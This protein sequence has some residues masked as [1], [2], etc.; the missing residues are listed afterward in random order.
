MVQIDC[1]IISKKQ[2][3][4]KY[5]LLTF[6][7]E[8]IAV[9][10]LP[11]QFVMVQ[12]SNEKIFLRRPFSICSAYSKT[13]DIF[14]KV[15]GVGSELLSKKNVGDVL[16]IIGPL[17]NGYH[18]Q[19]PSSNSPLLVAGGTG[20]ASILFLAQRF[21]LHSSRPTVFLGAKTKKDV[22][23]EKEFKKLGYKVIV[24][25]ED[26][27]EGSEGLVSDVFS[28][29]LFTYSLIHLSTIC[30][31]CGPKPMLE[32]VAKICKDTKLKCY[33]SLEE[34]MACGVGACVGCVVKIRRSM[35]PDII[36]VNCVRC[37]MSKVR[38]QE[39][40]YKRV[41]KDGPVF[42]AEKIIW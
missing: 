26:G 12:I 31:A 41:C 4:E 42:D 1:P 35:S 38:S 15:V 5:F 27:S 33:V 36:G 24:S 18:F 20:V 14:F 6:L 13:F 21:T 16:N 37:P 3:S 19:L 17:G 34:R 2:I 29:C 7:C 32:A 10:A 28:R 11:G 30:Y 22:L 23:F 39:F 9:M 25:T 8:K 40:E